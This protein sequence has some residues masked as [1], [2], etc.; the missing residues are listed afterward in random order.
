MSGTK[1]HILLQVV[2]KVPPAFADVNPYEQFDFWDNV[3]K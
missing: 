3:W 2:D 1:E